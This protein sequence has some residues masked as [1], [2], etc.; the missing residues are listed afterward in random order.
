MPFRLFTRGLSVLAAA[1]GLVACTA[2]TPT[3]PTPS[4]SPLTGSSS[5]SFKTSVAPLLTSSCV[6]CHT[7]TGTGAREIVIADATGQLDVATISRRA[8][9]ILREVRSGAMPEGGPKWTTEQ[10]TTFQTWYQAGAPNN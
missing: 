5:V 2:G 4:S 1:A 6:S 3:S 10:V 8:G 9:A 7:P